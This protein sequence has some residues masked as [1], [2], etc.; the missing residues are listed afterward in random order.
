MKIIFSVI[1]LL[2]STQ[3]T[4]GQSREIKI[5]SI[6]QAIHNQDPE[7][8]ISIGFIDNGKETFFNYGTISKESD[9]EVDENTIY[10][11]GSII[12]GNGVKIF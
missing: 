4:F 6:C 5:D 9:L 11:I 1:I 3:L 2:I 8:A 10:E 7:V 12:K